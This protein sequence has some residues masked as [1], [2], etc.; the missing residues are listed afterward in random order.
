MENIGQVTH[1]KFI[2]E[3]D[4]SLTEGFFNLTVKIKGSHDNSGN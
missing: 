4:G 3:V 2:M 1:I